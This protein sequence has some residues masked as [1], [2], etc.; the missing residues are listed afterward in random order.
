MSRKKPRIIQVPMNEEL[1]EQL[2]S[3]SSERGQSRSA[4][5]REACA[6]YVAKLTEEELDRRYAESYRNF[7]ESTENDEWRLKMAA[8]V[9]GE[10]DWSEEDW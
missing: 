10:E 8:E 9:W 5:I 4:F 2:D 1:L 7:P 6:E 3:Y